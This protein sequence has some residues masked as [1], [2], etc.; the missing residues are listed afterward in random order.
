MVG[1]E[2]VVKPPRPEL[3]HQDGRVGPYL[4]DPGQLGLGVPLEV[5]RHEL[6]V[7]VAPVG[8]ECGGVGGE[9]KTVNT[10]SS[11]H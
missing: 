11:Q 5:G 2:P 4:L 7:D 9:E 3:R 10:C 1:F 8:G 6:V